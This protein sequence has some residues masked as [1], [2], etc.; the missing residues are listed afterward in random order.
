MMSP[1][2][3]C[4]RCR[5]PVSPG[6]RFCSQCGFSPYVPHPPPQ[7]QPLPSQVYACERCLAV[8]PPG[9]AY[10]LR[11]GEPAYTGTA[12]IKKRKT[13]SVLAACVLSIV[14]GGLGQFYNG[15]HAKGAVFLGINLLL[16]LVKPRLSSE[17]NIVMVIF[18]AL[19]VLDAGLIAHRLKHGHGVKPW[20]FW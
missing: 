19:V 13:H 8:S 10:C 4:P 14:V 5:A 3:F 7:Q 15:Q 18:G 20:D 1:P 11:C 2:Q 9:S 17:L 12:L 16:I 6:S